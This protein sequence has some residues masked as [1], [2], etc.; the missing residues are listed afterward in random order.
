MTWEEL[1]EEYP[2]QKRALQAAIQGDVSELKLAYDDGAVME[3]FTVLASA[4]AG[5]VEC[6]KFIHETCN[7]PLVDEEDDGFNTDVITYVSNL[8]CLQYVREHG[9]PWRESAIFMYV[10]DQRLDCLYYAASH[11]CPYS[12]FDLRHLPD[13][14]KMNFWSARR[15]WYKAHTIVKYW[16]QYHN[17]TKSGVSI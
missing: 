7:M 15:R 14:I 1:L 16:K 13:E 11:G 17:L 3:I 9:V 8:E 2:L 6:L 5:S 12:A 4:A 10:R